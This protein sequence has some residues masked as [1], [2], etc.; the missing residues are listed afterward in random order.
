L[1]ALLNILLMATFTA[2]GTFVAVRV[3]FLTW[4][5][6][7]VPAA[8][9][10]VHWRGLVAGLCTITLQVPFVWAS[11]ALLG[12]WQG[13]AAQAAVLVVGVAGLPI[14]LEGGGP[15]YVLRPSFG[16][17]LGFLPAA[18]F[19]GLFVRKGPIGAF[20]GMVLGQLAMWAVGV[21]WQVGATRPP[22]WLDVT[23]WQRSWAGALQLAPTYLMLM[24]A[25]ALAIGI[26]AAAR[27]AFQSAF[28]QQR[29][30]A[31]VDKV[32]EH[33]GAE[34]PGAGR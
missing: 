19:A 6:P 27:Q 17:L 2:L 12:P 24:A 14:F 30:G 33:H 1:I 32:D 26:F 21:T 23:T 11:G 5:V 20:L 25:L 18:F 28:Q 16:Y 15:G 8:E 34:H 7:V 9:E 29:E 13:M 3:P 4:G 10:L 22:A 31:V